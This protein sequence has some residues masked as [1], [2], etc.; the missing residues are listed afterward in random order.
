MASRRSCCL[1]VFLP[2]RKSRKEG[3]IMAALDELDKQIRQR[4]AAS[5]E[6]RHKDHEYLTH[7]MAELEERLR[8]YNQVANHLVKELIRPRLGKLAG[9][10]ENAWVSIEQHGGHG[11]VCEF[12]KTPR[13]PAT[14][15]LAFE[16]TRDGQAHTVEIDYNVSIIPAF[17]PVP[18]PD[19]LTV[20]LEGLND[21]KVAAWVEEKIL[22]FV[23]A[24]LRLE[25][26]EEYQAAN[27]VIDPVCGM[28][29]NKSRAPASMEYGGAIYYFCVEEC[30]R[31]FAENPERYLS[32]RA[33]RS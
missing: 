10:F 21:E 25:T 19:R 11:C 23:D 18:R 9:Y 24:Y 4:I 16:V 7:G 6:R 15:T 30:R 17:S 13:F 27:T 33:G 8:R 22:A 32:G 14:A 3:V 31:R 20:P 26:A 29:L 28:S 1:S 12:A 2:C 5:E